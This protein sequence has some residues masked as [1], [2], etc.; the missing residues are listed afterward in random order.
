[1]E[2]IN[3]FIQKI[4]ELQK[5][6]DLIEKLKHDIINYDSNSNIPLECIQRIGDSDEKFLEKVE[7][8]ITL[9]QMAFEL[10]QLILKRIKEIELFNKK[11]NEML[12]SLLITCKKN[13][14]II[15]ANRKAITNKKE[16]I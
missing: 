13:L 9:Q 5:E 6:I 7:S 15:I 12:N 3:N 2:S 14:F 8:A 4:N 1:M 16:K 11:I 10:N